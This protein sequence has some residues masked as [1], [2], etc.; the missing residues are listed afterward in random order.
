VFYEGRPIALVANMA[1]HVDV[2]GYAPGSMPAGVHEVFQ[3][4]LQIPPVKIV[5]QGVLDDD[6]MRLMN[7]NVRT[8]IENRGDAMAQVAANNVGT[9]RL[10]EV[11]RAHGADTISFYMKALMD[12]SEV[13]M[14]AGI[15]S[16][17][18]TA[19]AP[20]SSAMRA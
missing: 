8:K 15:R 3:E 18:I 2:G 9:R 12:Y 5:K 19:A 14:R 11:I 13:R 6:L 20:D 10:E 4:G 17:A 7:E 1:H 16:S